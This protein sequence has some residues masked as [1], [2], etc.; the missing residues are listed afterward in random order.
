MESVG[1]PQRIMVEYTKDEERVETVETDLTHYIYEKMLDHAKNYQWRIVVDSHKNALELYFVVSL[2]NETDQYVQDVN[3]QVNKNNLIQFEDV[4]CLY[5]ETS[6]RIVPSNYLYALP[7][8]VELGIEEGHVDA[9][10]KQLNIIVSGANS[11]VREFL[12]D[13]SQDEFRLE[14]HELNFKNT[15]ETLQNT[16]NYSMNRLTFEKQEDKSLADQFKEESIN[17]V[18]RI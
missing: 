13:A 14:W 9:L 3:A 16:N 18:E 10:L 6:N 11:K 5:D 15:I 4:I 1:E 17:G 2:E 7:F 8:N 12:L